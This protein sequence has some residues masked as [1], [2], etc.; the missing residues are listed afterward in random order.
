[1][2]SSKQIKFGALI[3]YFSIA[4]NIIAGLVYTPWMISQIGQS[5]Y[6][7]YTL[8]NSLITLFIVDFGLGSAVSRY[9]SK[10][11]AEGDEEKVNNF[12]GAIYKLYAIID[13]VIFVV[14]L[15]LFFFLDVIYVKLSPIELEKF[16]VVYILAASYAVIHF[17]FFTLNGILTSY[18]KFVPLKLADLLCKVMTIGFTVVALLFGFGLYSLVAVHSIT[19]IITIALKLIFVK[20]LTPVKVNLKYGSRALYKDVFGFSVWVT[21]AS[22]AHRLIFNITPTILGIVASVSA[23]AVFG[24]ITTIEGYVYTITSAINGMFL[25]KISRIYSKGNGAE[26]NLT[27]LLLGVGKFQYALNGI[28]IVGFAVLGKQFIT[29]WM[30]ADYLDAYWGVLLVTVPGLFFNSLQIGNTALIV[31]N[32]VKYRAIVS[33]IAGIINVSLSFFFSHFFGVMGAAIS[34]FVA[35][36]FKA[37]ATNVVCYKVLKLDIPQFV[38]KCYIRMSLSSMVALL[39]SLGINFVIPD[40]G[41]GIFALKVIIVALVY[42]LCI[43]IMGINSSER[44]NVLGAISSKLKRS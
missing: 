36:M 21:V 9:V 6:G 23:I 11:R 5:D 1:M 44:K 25:P 14:L 31:Q 24:V 34:I 28:I 12:L 10:Y 22:L 13:A 41:W 3:S 27:P 35:Y 17:P 43:F 32:K 7:L 39:I 2:N 38:R 33:L 29:L 40:A 16:K 8:A 19:G 18:E 42:C 37:I 30:G 4:F 20:K 15:I 26:K